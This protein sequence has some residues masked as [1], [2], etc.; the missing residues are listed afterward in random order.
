[1][2]SFSFDTGELDQLKAEVKQ[3][4]RLAYASGSIRNLKLQWET[5]LL[6]CEKFSLVPFPVE[7]TTL[8]L[9]AQFL[10]RSFKSVSSI[11]NYV[12]GVRVLHSLTHTHFPSDQLWEYKLVLKGIEKQLN[13]T[14]KR[15]LP[16]TPAI[17]LE[18]YKFLCMDDPVDVTFW[19]LFL[20]AFFCMLRKSNLVP[21]HASSFDSN[22]HFT[23]SDF[24]ILNNYLLVHIKWSKTVQ[25]SDRKFDIPLPSIQHSPLCPVKAFTRM[26]KMLPAPSSA[27]AFFLPSH[28]SYKSITY[29]QY[30]LLF[31]YLVSKTG[32]D[33]K[34]FSSH[35]FR[36]G[37]A[38]WAF[39]CNV[40]SDLIKTH[41]DWRSDAYQKYLEFDLED[42]AK[43]AR[44]MGVS[45]F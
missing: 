43:V 41:G 18:F 4:R 45:N 26:V 17:L 5:F 11:Q 21:V 31:R 12:N 19:A 23:R 20:A 7:P 33:P 29:R 40:P 1:M 38:T 35:S 37:G 30:H 16:V 13:H 44:S 39:R 8:T 14:V 6:F 27:P 15:A 22:M 3:S 34:M 25:T 24:T 10:A 36:R 2:V 9:F 42:R 32:R 28:H